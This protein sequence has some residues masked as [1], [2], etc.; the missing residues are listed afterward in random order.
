MLSI[1]LNVV[2]KKKK[3]R[4]ECDDREFREGRCFAKPGCDIHVFRE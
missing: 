2:Q 3:S 1:V 4:G